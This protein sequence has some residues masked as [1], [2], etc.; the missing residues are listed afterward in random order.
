[1]PNWCDNTLELNHK[2]PAM[3]ARAKKAFEDM[4]FLNEFI[5][6]P[7]ELRKTTAP[8]EPVEELQ[9][10]YGYSNW[11]DFCVGEWGTKWDIGGGDGY[12]NSEDPNYLSL[13]FQSAWSPPIDAYK[14]LEAMGFDVW[15]IYYES[16]MMF[17]GAY[18]QGADEFYDIDAG[19]EWVR[20]NIPSYLDHAFGISDG[21][22]EWED[23]NEDEEE[24]A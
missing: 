18:G 1:M 13:S 11:Y 3:I 6:I 24:N 2:D 9:K 4:N 22:A 7:E 15:A 10:K 12:I 19:S 21:M 20:E 8:C 14:K 16:G 5:P 23:D 17:C